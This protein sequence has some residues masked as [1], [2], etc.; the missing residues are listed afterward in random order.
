MKKKLFSSG[1][2]YCFS[3][4]VL[5]AQIDPRITSVLGD[6]STQQKYLLELKANMLEERADQKLTD[7]K[8]D[9]DISSNRDSEDNFN[10]ENGQ[11]SAEVDILQELIFLEQILTTDLKMYEEQEPEESEI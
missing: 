11:S 6:L 10:Q 1:L 2:I 4:F 9:P 7:N 5:S 3:I 8:K